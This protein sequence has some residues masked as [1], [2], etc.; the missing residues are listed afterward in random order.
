MFPGLWIRKR[1]PGDFPS[2][3][4]SRRAFCA[5]CTGGPSELSTGCPHCLYPSLY[6]RIT[7]FPALSP[8][9][10]DLTVVFVTS[11]CPRRDVHRTFTQ[12]RFHIPPG[13]VVGMMGTMA[14]Y[15]NTT[16]PSE[17]PVDEFIAAVEHPVRR[18]DAAGPGRAVPPRHRPGTGHVGT[19][20]GRLRPVPLRIRFRPPRR[21]PRR[22]IL[23]AQ[24]E[25]VPLRTDRP[26]RRHRSSWSNWASTSSASPACTSTSWRMWTSG[27]SRS[28]SAR[29]TATSPRNWTSRGA[30]ADHHLP[31]PPTPAD[32]QCFPLR[33]MARWF[34]GAG[35][36][37][38]PRP[39]G[40]SNPARQTR[41]GCLPTPSPRP[42]PSA[43]VSGSWS[44]VRAPDWSP[45]RSCPTS[46]P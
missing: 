1:F 37:R 33:D 11:S 28:S 41:P 42:C 31:S 27:C 13:R 20:H 26:S 45:R 14:A 4:S 9:E 3:N 24:G 18:A 5:N 34:H 8:A 23:A 32:G 46:A 38:Q 19:H 6:A 44:T 22:R 12:T 25:P 2:R 30:P 7:L 40:T 15:E 36:L 10:W 39:R 21:C 43:A 17:I 29:G 35:P 16:K